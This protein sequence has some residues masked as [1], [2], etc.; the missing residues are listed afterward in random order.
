MS[1]H[2]VYNMH[3]LEGITLNTSDLF[4][5]FFRAD[6]L[7]R[8]WLQ[9]NFIRKSCVKSHFLTGRGGGGTNKKLRS[10][11]AFQ[12]PFVTRKN[13]YMFALKIDL[14]QNN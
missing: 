12:F 9:N 8:F 6:R 13:V 4:D 7:V 10:W 1:K 3:R 14:G 5:S 2:L 11:L